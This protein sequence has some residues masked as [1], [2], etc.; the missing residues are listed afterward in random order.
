M[1]FPSSQYLH[2]WLIFITISLEVYV[3]GQDPIKIMPLGNSI[4]QG[5]GSTVSSTGVTFNTWRR[6]LWKDL[7]DT[8]G[9]DVDFIGS[10]S[11]AHGCEDYTDSG[12]DWDHEGHWTWTIDDIV[13]GRSG[14]CIGNGRLR[15]W[16][17]Q[18]DTPDNV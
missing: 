2:F 14:V 10:I 9:F 16:I 15:E 12:F 1:E 11:Q 8:S 4:T 6:N 17:V 18:I 3:H 5:E 13:Y 7:V